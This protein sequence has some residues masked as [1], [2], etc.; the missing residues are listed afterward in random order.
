MKTTASMPIKL[1]QNTKHSSWVIQHK[2]N[3]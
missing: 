2:R 1:W 3:N